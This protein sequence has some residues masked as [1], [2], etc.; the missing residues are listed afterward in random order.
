MRL[1]RAAN[2]IEEELNG[3]QLRL[4]IAIALS[5]ALP[6]LA[7]NRVRTRL[8]RLAGVK[9]GK[10]TVFGGHLTIAGARGAHRRV[11]IG[12]RGWINA[13]CYLDASDQIRIGDD[14]A[15]AQRVL[16][17]TQTHQVGRPDR[18]AGTL[19]TAPVTI[20]DGCWIGAGAVVLPGVTIGAG[21]IVAAGA[22]VNRD[23][24]PNT[25][26][27]GVPARPVKDLP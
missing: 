26:V 16:V 10:A 5:G 24:A 11:V 14:V 13:D 4:T 21:S 2:A 25:L 23:V 19:D 18:R 17:L 27:A 8:F 20:G 15:I 3:V 7:G 6:D 12:R 22:V 9:V 1:R